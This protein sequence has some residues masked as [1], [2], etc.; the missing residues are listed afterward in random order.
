ML[1]V[2][3]AWRDALAPIVASESFAS[4]A[5]FVDEERARATVYPPAPATFAALAATPPS[6]VRVVVVGQDPYHGPGQAH[7]LAFSVPRGVKKPP[8]LANIL[9][10]LVDDV[11]C[12]IPAHGSLDAWAARG[13]LLLNT[14]LTVRDGAP[15]SHKGRGWE[16]FT[17]AVLRVVDAGPR[18][19]VF[20]LWGGPAQKKRALVDEQ[21]HAVLCCA[22]PS[23][24]SAARGFFGSKPFSRANGALIRAGREPIDWCL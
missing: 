19:V 10:E 24:L 21:R 17:D 22:H 13:V 6:A 5:R 2:P 4:L 23:P 14:I 7:G 12:A 8:S 15:L 11:G 20:L 1:I 9:K 16:A 18:G 3:P